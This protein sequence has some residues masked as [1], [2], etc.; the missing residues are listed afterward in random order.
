[1]GFSVLFTVHTYQFIKTDTTVGKICIN[2]EKVW[3]QD[4]SCTV[5][6]PAGNI[7]IKR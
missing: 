2:I 1:L 3:L 7:R 6:D 4:W 5:L